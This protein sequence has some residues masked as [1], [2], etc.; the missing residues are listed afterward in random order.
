[1]IAIVTGAS[2]GIGKAI[3]DGLRSDGWEAIGIS[4]H[5]PDININLSASK[6]II[7]SLLPNKKINLLVNCAGIMKL[8]E[9]GFE[10][11]IMST[12]FWGTLYTMEHYKDLDLF[13][14]NAC[15]INIASISA[16]TFDVDMPMYSASKAAVI[17]MSK[18]LAKKWA[19]KVR[20]NCISPGFYNTELVEGETPQHLIRQI[21][22]GYEDDPKNLYAIIKTIFETKYMTGSNII[23]D[24][25]VSL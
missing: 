5:G 10:H 23:I 16:D 3:Y 13:E 1:M 25:G 18:C 6:N 21:P 12:N 19:P 20:V 7:W 15:V 2:S 9:Q 14:D 11:S 17:A 4:R 22:M 8:R 24:G